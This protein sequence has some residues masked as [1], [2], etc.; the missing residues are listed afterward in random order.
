M[1]DLQPSK[2]LDVVF[3]KLIHAQHAQ[4]LWLKDRHGSPR[5]LSEGPSPGRKNRLI[6][7]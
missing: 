7:G 2:D 5:L 4:A 3:I 1:R 6:A